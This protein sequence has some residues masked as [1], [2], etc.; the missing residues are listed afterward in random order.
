[1]IMGIHSITGYVYS[2]DLIRSCFP[3]PLFGKKY[4]SL[5][6]ELQHEW[7]RNSDRIQVYKLK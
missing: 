3:K 1:M 5:L 2:K 7:H 6:L 4:Y